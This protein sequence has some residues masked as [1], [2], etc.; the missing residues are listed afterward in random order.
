MPGG[1]VKFSL[2]DVAIVVLFPMGV[3]LVCSSVWRVWKCKA[4]DLPLDERGNKLVRSK[5]MAVYDF[6]RV[7]CC[8]EERAARTAL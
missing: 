5:R 8:S 6:F 1:W 3:V 2:L 7:C 4:E